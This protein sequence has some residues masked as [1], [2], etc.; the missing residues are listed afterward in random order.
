MKNR[1]LKSRTIKRMSITSPNFTIMLFKS[2]IIQVLFHLPKL[3][4]NN[5][6][7]FNILSCYYSPFRSRRLIFWVWGSM[8]GSS[9]SM[10]RQNKAD[11]GTNINICFRTMRSSCALFTKPILISNDAVIYL[12]NYNPLSQFVGTIPSY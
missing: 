12:I 7:L 1:K 4:I 10:W 2:K 9:C 11:S 3:K 8:R 5:K 6:S